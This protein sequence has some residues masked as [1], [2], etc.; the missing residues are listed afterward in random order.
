[1]EVKIEFY[2]LNKKIKIDRGN[3][4]IF[5]EINKQTKKILVVFQI[6]IYYIISNFVYL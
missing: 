2:G 5:N 3:G 1:M 6:K 4:F